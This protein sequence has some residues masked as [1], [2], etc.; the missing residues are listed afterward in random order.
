MTSNRPESP[1]AYTLSYGFG[2]DGQPHVVV[3][4]GRRSLHNHYHVGDETITRAFGALL[5]PEL[6]D[7]VDVALAVYVADRLCPRRHREAS[8]YDLNWTRRFYIRVPLRN[9]ELW[10]QS[11]VTR[12]LKQLLWFF[13]EDKWSF[14]FVPRTRGPRSTEIQAGLFPMN[15]ASPVTAALFS[16]GLD[17]LAGLCAELADSQRDTFVLF[18]GSTNTEARAV[19]RRLI[20]EVRARFGREVILVTV[21]F[22]LRDRAPGQHDESTQRSRGFVFMALGAV[23]AI[24]AGA[25]GLAIY[26]NGVGAINLPYTDGQLGAHSTRSVHPAALAA[27][28]DLV[29]LVTGRD[30]AFRLPFLFHTKGQVC[31]RLADAGLGSL[32]STANSC[33]GFPQRVPGHP[34]CGRC[35]SCLLRRQALWAARLHEVDRDT[36][37]IHDVL[38]DLARVPDRRLH[39]WRAMLHQVARLQGALNQDSPWRALSREYPQLVEVAAGEIATA[40]ASS[41]AEERLVDLYRRYCDEWA[42]FPAALRSPLLKHT[43]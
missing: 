4:G 12:A 32:G 11:S 43:A 20:A 3:D 1:P 2:P 29:T 36:H 37:Y 10:S 34:H 25:R 30:F 38:G 13:T 22:G 42:R 24:E 9:P 6:A 40:M 35:T 39:K 8:A 21:P 14:E 7:L 23:T 31:A 15:P 19:Q 33:D 16:G 18:A 27:M 41:G 5:S 17:S 26:E 28:A